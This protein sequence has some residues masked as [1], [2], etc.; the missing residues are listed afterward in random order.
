MLVTTLLTHWFRRRLL[1]IEVSGRSMEPTLRRG[2]LLLC[3]R[4]AT[5]TRRAIVVWWHP[6]GSAGA[7]YLVKRAVGLAGDRRGGADIPE[8]YLW[9]EGDARG[10]SFDS[11]RVGPISLTR[12]HAVAIARLADGRLTDLRLAWEP[13]REACDETS[14]TNPS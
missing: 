1:V 13:A 5:P 2:D 7:H 3:V 9:L 12:V 4:G 14:I 10:E 11:R 6:D 8:G